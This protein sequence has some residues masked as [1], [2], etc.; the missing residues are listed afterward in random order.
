MKIKNL[1][2]AWLL[3]LL[4]LLINI[5]VFTSSSSISFAGS[6]KKVANVPGM[7]YIPAG[8]FW[9]GCNPKDPYCANVVTPPNRVL[10]DE[11][12]YHEVYLDAY[13]IDKNDV[14][15]S[16]YKKCVD[17]QGCT[18]PVMRKYGN[19]NGAGRENH[20]VTWMN[21]YQVKAYCKWAGETLPTEAQWEKAARGTDGRF[22]PWGNHWDASKGCF[23]KSSTCVVGS[24]P[25]WASPY[26]VMDMSGNVWQW[27]ND[28]YDE[29]YYSNS[30]DHNPKGPMSG[31]QHIFRGGS[32]T[33]G[34]AS[35][36]SALRFAIEPPF[37]NLNIGF[38][39]VRNVSQ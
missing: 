17:A 34:S 4:T 23:D 38:R 9:M 18:P 39:C 28:W 25:Q 29:H 15:V 14:T 10:T 8:W 31:Y 35:L 32:W 16:E 7:V 33:A 3:V 26:G 30:P 19:W 37:K 11:K 27:V 5:V 1:E 6:I 12:P 2:P 20:P 36:R 21:W 24:Y 13:Y 22:Y